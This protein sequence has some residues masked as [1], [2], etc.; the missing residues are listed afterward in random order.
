MSG[1]Y[2]EEMIYDEGYWEGLRVAWCQM[3]QLVHV[4]HRAFE[5]ALKQLAETRDRARADFERHKEE[6][7]E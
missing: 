2:N 1:V 4:E 6:D 7:L 3:F 5:F